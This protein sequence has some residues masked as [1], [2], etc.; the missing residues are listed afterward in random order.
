[1]VDR[2]RYFPAIE[3]GE[4]AKV[5]QGQSRLAIQLLFPNSH[6]ELG[7]DFLFEAR[8]PGGF[9][10]LGPRFGNVSLEIRKI[11]E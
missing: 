4:T 10:P 1:M 5:Q 6:I 3:P 2:L 8:L 9:V 11:I 7:K